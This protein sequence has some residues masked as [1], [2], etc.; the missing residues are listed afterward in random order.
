MARK[1][2]YR[3]LGVERGAA[4]EEIKKAYRRLAKQYHPDRNKGNP[5]A[6]A[7]FKE[8]SEAYSV[9]SDPEKRRRY[10][11]FGEAGA[12][13]G[14][15]PDLWETIMGG[16]RRRGPRAETISYE[17]LGD[18][19]DLFSR[20]FTSDFE[21]TGARA[22]PAAPESVVTRV[23]IPFDLAAKGGKIKVRVPISAVCGACGG[24]GADRSKGISRC[25]TCGGRGTVQMAMGGFAI[26]RPCPQCLGRGE[27]ITKACA[28][29]G[30]SGETRSQRTFMVDVPAGVRDGRRIR[31]RG[32]GSESADGV[33]GD[34]VV[35]FHVQPHETFRREGN[36][37]YSEAT[38]NIVQAA[39]GTTLPVETLEGRVNVKVPPGA[40][41]GSRLRLKGKGI[42]ADDG[43][44]GDHYV[45]LQ[46]A[47]PADLT[48]EQRRLLER[49]AESAH[50]AR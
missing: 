34:V 9:L 30:G 39:L 38:I 26:S 28:Q 42:R 14:F 13:G 45:I 43:T 24:T 18:L 37:V 4:P 27:I 49:F 12:S 50:L 17:D 5:E 3:V 32:Q 2:Y 46:I 10:D 16:A 7:R 15:G 11:Q 44:V 19:G 25:R 22:R 8:I 36:D 29:C 41:S 20:F 48:D 47:A 35:E 23:S 1:D 6:E 21:P 31:L 33:R 40:R